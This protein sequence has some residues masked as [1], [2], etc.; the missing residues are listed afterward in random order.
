MRN[1]WYL[2][3]LLN[4]NDVNGHVQIMAEGRLPKRALK[5]MPKQK[6]ERGRPKENWMDGIKQ[7]MDERNLSEGQWE[8]RKKWRLGVGQRR[9]TF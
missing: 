3:K 6:R 5:W 7:V 9:K 8:D 2:I 4:V 1:Y